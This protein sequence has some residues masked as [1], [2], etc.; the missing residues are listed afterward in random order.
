MSDG[1][2]EKRECFYRNGIG[3]CRRYEEGC[4]Y[5]PVNF[6]HQHLHLKVSQVHEL[7]EQEHCKNGTNPTQEGS[8]TIAEGCCWRVGDGTDPP[9]EGRD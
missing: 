6:L 7:Y 8:N 5:L 4:R 1:F 9:V 2:C 3:Y